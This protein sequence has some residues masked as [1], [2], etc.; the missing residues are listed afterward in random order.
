MKR[1]LRQIAE[2][3]QARLQGNGSVEIEGVAS[4]ASASP[5]DLV[6]VEEQKHLPRAVHSAAGAIIA[7]EFAAGS[8]SK[9]LII[10]D[11]PKLA[12]A[13]AARFLQQ[14]NHDGLDTTVHAAAVVHASARL[15]A[16]AIVEE[17][18][19]IAADAEITHASVQ[20]APSGTESESG[21]SAK[22]IRT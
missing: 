7:G 9:P 20:V 5:L 21:G 3:V 1:S 8:T 14:E 12:F 16:G 11:H 6:F 10:S 13:R 18:A 15:A 19:V 22:S 4:I 17:L 2:A